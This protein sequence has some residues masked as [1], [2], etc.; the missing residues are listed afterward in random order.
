MLPT[1]SIAHFAELLG[2]HPKAML[3]ELQFA[4]ANK[5]SVHAPFTDADAATLRTYYLQRHGELPAG[6]FLFGPPASVPD[7]APEVTLLRHV[8]TR[9]WTTYPLTR[10]EE[11]VL[12][13]LV[14]RVYGGTAARTSLVRYLAAAIVARAQVAYPLRAFV[15]HL[16][17]KGEW[18]RRVAVLARRAKAALASA[19][20]SCRA[21][22]RAA[23]IHPAIAPPSATV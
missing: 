9:D 12:A 15:A 1:L 14:G 6:G 4:G 22:Q 5:A 16:S 10:Y 13:V 18:L 23:S 20:G 17:I 2:L 7:G 8:F 21:A 3:K 19:V 11:A